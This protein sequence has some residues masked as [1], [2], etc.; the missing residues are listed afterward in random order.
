MLKTSTLQIKTRKKNS[1]ACT[2]VLEKYFQKH[3]KNAKFWF[4][5]FCQNTHLKVVLPTSKY[6]KWIFWMIFSICYPEIFF[7][8]QIFWALETF[9]NF[10]FFSKI[11]L[12]LQICI[13]EKE[14]TKLVVKLSSFFFSSIFF[15]SNPIPETPVGLASLGM[16]KWKPKQKCV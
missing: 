10:N 1:S 12:F 11:K 6:K 8:G 5:D 16:K 3:F 13:E 7:M 4:F 14:G 15:F 2:G 9:E